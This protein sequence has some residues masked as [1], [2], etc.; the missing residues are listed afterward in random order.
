MKKLVQ[1]SSI[2]AGLIL[3]VGVSVASAFVIAEKT[4]QQ[5]LRK[6]V[7]KRGAKY[8]Q[9]LVKAATK[10]EKGGATS[11]IECH[12]PT[13]VVDYA[14]DPILDPKNKQPAKFQGDI[15]KCDEKYTPDKKGTDYTGIGCPGDC[16]AGAVGTQKCANIA[17]YEASVEATVGFTAKVQ[18]P[19]LAAG[20]DAACNLDLGGGTNSTNPA[21][22]NC[23]AEQA[24]VLSKYSKFLGKCYEKCE[25]DYKDKKGNGGPNDDPKCLVTNAGHDATFA[26]CATDG[27]AK[28]T[29]KVSLNPSVVSGVLPVLHAALDLANNGLYNRFDPIVSDGNPCGTCGNGTREGAEECDGADATM[30]PGMCAAACT[31]P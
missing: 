20:L 22:M 26:P 11:G 3:I 12:L 30:C 5:T 29:K 24:A 14:G 1:V 2:T 13:G 6:D 25:N 7:G 23:V 16:D 10:C 17:A 28:A 15:A 9:C 21:N 4:D 31:C 18:L 8:I 19:I 27:L